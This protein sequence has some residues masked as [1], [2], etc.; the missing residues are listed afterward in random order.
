MEGTTL[1][2]PRLWPRADGRL[3]QCVDFIR[4]VIKG[5]HKEKPGHRKISD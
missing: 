2:T 3:G 1:R 4:E 5:S